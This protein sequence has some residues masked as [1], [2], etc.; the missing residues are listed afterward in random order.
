MRGAVLG[1]RHGVLDVRR[2]A[3]VGAAQRP[4]VGGDP[5]VVTAT[6]EEPGLDR[7]HQAGAQ[8]QPAAGRP[9]F[10]RR[11]LVHGAAHAVPALVGVDPAAPGPAHRTDRR[12]DVADAVADD[13]RGDPGRQRALGG[14]DESRSSGRGV[15]TGKVIAASPTQP[16]RV[17][18]A[19]TLSRSPSSSSC[20]S[21]CRAARRR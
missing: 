2:A 17:A 8:R 21:G 3:A 13:G 19:S 12:R 6:G 20:G 10:G 11:R 1:D 7:D 15:P 5:V 9:S 14:R 18:P 16:S 4:A